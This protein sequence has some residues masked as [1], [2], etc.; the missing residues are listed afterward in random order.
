MKTT[1]ADQYASLEKACM[2]TNA[3]DIQRQESKRFFYAGAGAI[4]DM[5]LHTVARSD[6]SEADGILILKTLHE[7]VANFVQQVQAGRA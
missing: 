7:E 5:M 6:V 2:P 4:L 1:I 3:S